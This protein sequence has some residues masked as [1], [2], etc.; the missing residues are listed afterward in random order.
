MPEYDAA[1][2]GSRGAFSEIASWE[3]LGADARLLPCPRLEEV[4]E[5]VLNNYLAKE[6]GLPVGK[7]VQVDSVLTEV[8]CLSVVKPGFMT[9]F[10][11]EFEDV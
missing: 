5:A 10:R 9:T 7:V 1:F 8:P 2:Q 6:I 4:F 3:L 11:I